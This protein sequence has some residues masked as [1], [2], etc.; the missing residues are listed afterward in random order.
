VLNPYRVIEPLFTKEL[1]ERF[2][3]CVK[4]GFIELKE[5]IPH[6]WAIAADTIIALYQYKKN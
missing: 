1:F 2:Q 4:K 5:H 6:V 3:D